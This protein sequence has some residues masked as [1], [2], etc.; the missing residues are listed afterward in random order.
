MSLRRGKK[1]ISSKSKLLRGK[2]VAGGGYGGGMAMIRV[3]ALPP[4]DKSG[5]E[6][7]HTLEAF[8]IGVFSRF[9][10]QQCEYP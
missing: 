10:V 4:S 9:C 5:F 7:L 8:P 2:E 6:G 3:L 1:A